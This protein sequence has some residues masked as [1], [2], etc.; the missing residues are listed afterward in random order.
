MLLMTHAT[1]G[2]PAALPT[3][4]T[5]RSTSSTLRIHN[6]LLPHD[7]ADRTTRVKSVVT[8][9]VIVELLYNRSE[10]FC[11]K[12]ILRK[13]RYSDTL[14]SKQESVKRKRSAPQRFT[15]QLHAGLEEGLEWDMK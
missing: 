6:S 10:C 12:A 14:L 4:V 8:L 11:C 1:L 15:P 9:Q 3:G 5:Q 2:K 7:R 13:R